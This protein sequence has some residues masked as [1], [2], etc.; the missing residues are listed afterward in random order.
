MSFKKYLNY[1]KNIKTEKFIFPLQN[2]ILS[3]E[4]FYNCV[5]NLDNEFKHFN[6]LKK[7]S[8]I[9]IFYENSVEY[10]LLS[11][12]LINKGFV[13]VPINTTLSTKEIRY[14]LKVSSS[15]FIIASKNLKKKINFCNKII[16]FDF[17][18]N[19]IKKQNKKYQ[20]L[21]INSSNSIK[22]PSVLLFTSG[23]TGKP[24]GS[25]LTLE[26]IL[27]NAR[28]IAEHHK[29]NHNSISLVLMPMFHN[30]G[31][32]GT[33]LSNFM[34]GGKLIVVPAN[35]ILLKFWHFIQK[36]KV[37]H[38]SVMVSVLS[39]ITTLNTPTKKNYLKTIAVGGQKAPENL[40]KRFE[41][42]FKTIA[43]VNYG[44]TE[45]TSISAAVPLDKKIRKYNSIGKPLPGVKIK[46][47]D[48]EK[49]T[50][51]NQGIGEICITGKNVIKSYFDDKKLTRER[52]FK[53][54]LKTG[55]FG[56][57][58]KNKNLYFFSRKDLLI[59]KNGENIYPIEIENQ[60]Y[61][62]KNIEECAVVG[63]EDK[64]YGDEI[65]AFIKGKNNYLKED[66][67]FSFLHKNLAKFKIPKKLFFLG[68]NIKIKEFP[69]TA[70]KK[71]LYPKLMQ[72]VRNEISKK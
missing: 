38:T 67:I 30:N 6:N 71:I 37:T 33:F 24:K 23:S 55:D 12:Y 46:I 59:I 7:G 5:T 47:L 72:I 13:L 15:S 18:K 70:S 31:Y 51:K 66:Y 35:L 16:F 53:K 42:K 69:K 10:I 22:R 50:L 68:K 20:N 57:I 43:V 34:V 65:Y 3:G 19:L 17:S 40:I 58:D 25:L 54:Y 36:Y 28:A 62:I 61:K 26:N 11:T 52:F 49:N 32:V 2:L 56:K 14:I 39:M 41:K 48:E 9:S 60:L 29:L 1:Y 8:R 4:E 63:I 45:T 27:F 44:L 64:I 21:L